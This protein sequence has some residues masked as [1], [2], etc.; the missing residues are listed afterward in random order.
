MLPANV[1]VEHLVSVSDQRELG[2]CQFLTLTGPKVNML[3]I[4]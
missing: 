1:T 2:L 3:Y 4:G